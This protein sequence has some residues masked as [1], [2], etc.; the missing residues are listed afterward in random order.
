MFNE[1]WI[2]LFYPITLWIIGFDHYY[3]L[4][5]SLSEFIDF[6]LIIIIMA[7]TNKQTNQKIIIKSTNKVTSDEA[8]YWYAIEKLIQ[9][10]HKFWWAA[11]SFILD[12]I[13]F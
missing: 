10:F 6:L 7:I 1:K 8:Y 4:C 13:E 11:S 9:N 3:I 2:I 12:D 5:K